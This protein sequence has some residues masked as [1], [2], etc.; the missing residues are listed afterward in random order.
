MLSCSKHVL[1]PGGA[2]VN[3]TARALGLREVKALAKVTQLLKQWNWDVP[4]QGV[5]FSHT[6]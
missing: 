3:K 2:A 6:T 5:S 4:L 1:R